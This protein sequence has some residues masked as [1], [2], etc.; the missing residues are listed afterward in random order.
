METT[1]TQ[2]SGGVRDPVTLERL[3][4]GA[5]GSMEIIAVIA[6]LPAGQ[7]PFSAFRGAMD[8][9]GW[10]EG[11]GSRHRAG[12]CSPA[13]KGL[14]SGRRQAT[15]GGP[16]RAPRRRQVVGQDGWKL[17]AVFKTRDEWLRR[18]RTHG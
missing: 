2:K 8:A 11:C 4:R 12:L 16:A 15:Q 7:H 3:L 5:P 13:D 6:G 14:A 1:P 18:A 17:A 10:R 9:R